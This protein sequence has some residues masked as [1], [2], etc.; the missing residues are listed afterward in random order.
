MSLRLRSPSRRRFSALRSL[1]HQGRHRNPIKM[2]KSKSVMS[3]MN[4]AVFV[5]MVHGA[6]KLTHVLAHLALGQRAVRDDVVQH[7]ECQPCKIC[8]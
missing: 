5:K 6:R 4:H 8:T 7:L 2:R 1:T 3:P